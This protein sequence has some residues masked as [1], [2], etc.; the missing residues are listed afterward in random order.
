MH[1]LFGAL[2]E[3][4]NQFWKQ[5]SYK[6]LYNYNSKK[7]FR[8]VSVRTRKSALS[9][10]CIFCLGHFLR[11]KISFESR[12]LIKCYIITIKFFFFERFG[13]NQ[14]TCTFTFMHFLVGALSEVK[15]QF[16]KQFSYKWLFNNW[17][18]KKTGGF[19]SKPENLHI[20]FNAF[21]GLIPPFNDQF[22][23]IMTDSTLLLIDS[24]LIMSDWMTDSTL[25]MTDSTLIMTDSTL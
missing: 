4:K 18:K 21:S 7:I 13:Q 8:S 20:H 16:R 3:V 23:P 2:P 22:Y 9:L 24:T 6:V 11:S 5:F 25:L 1:F 17:A 15:N 14:K 12:F 10:S 19:W